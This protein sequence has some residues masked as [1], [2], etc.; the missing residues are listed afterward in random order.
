M[1]CAPKVAKTFG[2]HIFMLQTIFYNVEF[3]FL[4]RELRAA[5]ACLNEIF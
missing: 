4:P 3:S 1:S 2:A 5:L